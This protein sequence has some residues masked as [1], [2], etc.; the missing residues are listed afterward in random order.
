MA[1]PSH[2]WIPSNQAILWNYI[3]FHGHRPSNWC[4]NVNLFC[5]KFPWATPALAFNFP[6]VACPGSTRAFSALSMHES[7][8]GTDRSMQSGASHRD[9]AGTMVNKDY[10]YY[11]ETL[12][13]N[14]SFFFTWELI[15]FLAISWTHCWMN[16]CGEQ[17]FTI[18]CLNVAPVGNLGSILCR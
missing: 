16:V 15:H 2:T 1:T 14:I 10:T 9:G 7:Q 3:H 13:I 8:F 18:L 4:F 11:A 12:C 5:R 6:F 17:I